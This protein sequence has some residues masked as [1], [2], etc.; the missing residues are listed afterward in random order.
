MVSVW[1]YLLDAQILAVECEVEAKW[2]LVSVV[3]WVVL[4]DR[5]KIPKARDWVETC[6]PKKRMVVDR[7]RLPKRNLAVDLGR[8]SLSVDF[9]NRCSY[10][11]G[12]KFYRS[13]ESLFSAALDR[14]RWM[15]LR[16][17]CFRTEFA[18]FVRSV[19]VVRFVLQCHQYH[20]LG[21][22]QRPRWMKV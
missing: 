18:T 12:L 9:S 2:V 14:C 13:G 16:S 3:A 11:S 10:C 1:E 6:L 15:H 5:Q 19:L 7:P 4:A 21:E 22:N 20:R 8:P 17:V